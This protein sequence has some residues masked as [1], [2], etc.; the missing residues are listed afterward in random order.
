MN[1]VD[2]LESKSIGS[3]NTELVTIFSGKCTEELENPAIVFPYECDEFQKFAFCCIAK[4]ED[5][6]ATAHTGSG[7]T[8]LGEYAIIDTIKRGKNVVYTSPIKSLSNEKFN[9]FRKKFSSRDDFDLGIMTGDNKINPNGNCIIMTAEILRNALYRLKNP[10]RIDNTK[11]DDPNNIE[12]KEEFIDKLGCVVIDEIHFI[13]LP[14]RGTVYEET[15]VLLDKGVQLIMLSATID[16]A[17]QFASWIAKTRNKRIN[18]IPTN[19]RVVPLRH[20]IFVNDKLYTVLE[21]DDKYLQDNLLIAKKEYNANIE[22]R[23]KKHMSRIDFNVVT[24]L[25]KYLKKHD[26]LQTIFFSFSKKNCEQYANMVTEPLLT[27]EEIKHATDIF[28]MSLVTTKNASYEKI[29]QCNNVRN[30]ISKGVAFH[31]AGLIPILKEIIELLFKEGL[32][33][34]LFATETFAVGVNMPTRTV[35]FT[36]LEKFTN[37]NK[38]F[39]TTAEYKQMS[40]RAGRRG[41][42]TA[43][44]VIILPIYDLP[45]EQQFRQ[46]MLGKIN[47]ITSQFKID[48]Q[49]VLKVLQSITILNISDSSN[50][51]PEINITNSDPITNI[52]KFM[53]KS[54]F[55]S[56]TMS[57]ATSIKYELHNIDKDINKVIMSMKPDTLNSSL[58][59]SVYNSE[60]PENTFGTFGDIKITPSKSQMK[61]QKQLKAQINSNNKEEYQKFVNYMI[62]AKKKKNVER[63]LEINEKYI[64]SSI[65]LVVSMLKISGYI[66]DDNQIMKKGVIAA[67][68]NECN[69]ILLTEMIENKVFNGLS[70]QEIIAVISIF[71]EPD[72]T[73]EDTQ[74]ESQSGSLTK[75]VYNRIKQI[76]KIIEQYETLEDKM[77]LTGVVSWQISTDF[78]DASYSWASGDPINVTVNFLNGMYIGSFIRNIIK[79]NNIAKDMM[80]LC[81]IS[82]NIDIIPIL[83]QVEEKLI[84]DVVTVNSLY[85]S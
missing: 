83:G 37:K 40:G 41:I 38:R 19:H 77:N 62:L 63:D 48:Y 55:Y 68:I 65:D 70:V 59:Q 34:I 9:D 13:N 18:L 36:E 66:S 42:D 8:T 6:L 2:L 51:N 31:H 57:I 35:V 17:E 4:G 7:K 43:G 45:D 29:D 15:I 84:R 3:P 71:I 52:Y 47:S 69:C 12:I 80:S 58:F 85:L 49:F 39:L 74:I 28:D 81:Q 30:L 64:E 56:D 24:D 50:N 5:V 20:H 25:V 78:I 33:K 22:K 14:D 32:I 44:T 27:H 16:K 53:R 72:K 73:D 60:K 26:L 21:K 61:Q 75:E 46:I 10:N 82:G 67:Q 23:E 11:L 79:I 76:K 1:F 54:L